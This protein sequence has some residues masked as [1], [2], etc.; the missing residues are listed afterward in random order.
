MAEIL[1]KFFAF[2]RKIAHGLIGAFIWH[3]ENKK[4]MNKTID[5]KINGIYDVYQ[6]SFENV[7]KSLELKRKLEEILGIEFKNIE[8][9]NYYLR[10]LLNSHI[11][12]YKKLIEQSMEETDDPILILLAME[13]AHDLN[14]EDN[15]LLYEKIKKFK[16]DPLKSEISENLF[17]F[18]YYLYIKSKISKN[19]SEIDKWDREKIKYFY[20]EIK[21][22]FRS[23]DVESYKDKIHHISMFLKGLISLCEKMG[24]DCK[25]DEYINNIF[26]YLYNKN[27]ILIVQNEN[28]G[29][30]Y[31]LMDAILEAIDLAEHGKI[32]LDYDKLAVIYESI[33]KRYLKDYT[34]L[35]E[36]NFDRVYY[37]TILDLKLLPLKIGR[38]CD[39]IT[40]LLGKMKQFGMFDDF[41]EIDRKGIPLLYSN[42]RHTL[43]CLKLLNMSV[44]YLDTEKW[45]PILSRTLSNHGIYHHIE[46]KIYSKGKAMILLI[47][48]IIVFG[49]SFLLYRYHL[50][51]IPTAVEIVIDAII[52]QAITSIIF[53]MVQPTKVIEEIEKLFEDYIK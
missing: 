27:E 47:I 35:N 11:S 44:E 7:Y 9:I 38:A 18:G 51:D 10:K 1:S 36:F 3:R 12:L 28:L 4:R 34:A 24:D 52:I 39:T 5:K 33:V 25:Y 49:V 45:N 8:S 40:R 6:A 30:L 21:D 43:K 23:F 46:K 31:Y 14:I 41:P 50:L 37:R 26:S 48:L 42:P 15:S 16:K 19:S 53:Y 17:N 20:S 22:I 2:I 32:E 29:N 13:V